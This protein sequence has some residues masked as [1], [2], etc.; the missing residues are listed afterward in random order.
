MDRALERV[1]RDLPHHSID[2]VLDLGREHRLALFVVARRGQKLPE[3]QH[4]AEHARGLR[5]SQRRRRHQRAVGCSQHLMHA[6][7][8]FVRER[9]HVARLALVVEQHIGMGRRYGW[10][11]ERARRLAWAALAR[12]SSGRSKKRSAISAIFGENAP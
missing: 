6:V 10:M 2:H 7:A 3:R 1:E 11:S 12:Q 4:L 8:K 5:E 9:H